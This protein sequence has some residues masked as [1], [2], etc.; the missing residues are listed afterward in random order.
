MDNSAQTPGEKKGNFHKLDILIT[1]VDS[2]LG[3]AL[4]DSLL[5][6]NCAIWGV[7][8]SPL[9][10]EL[11]GKDDFTLLE[12]DLAQPLP[13]HLPK[14]ELIFYLEL[15]RN[16]L[17]QSTLTKPSLPPPLT[18]LVS[19]V[20]KEDVKL[21]VCAPLSANLRF[22]DYLTGDEKTKA[23][24][25]VLLLGDLYGPRMP[26]VA[27]EAASTRN[28]L[29]NLVHQA[30]KTDKIILENEGL[31][32]IYPTYITDAI[33]AINKFV[34]SQKE[35]QTATVASEDAKTALSCAY[36]I[37]NALNLVGKKQIG[38][39]F[40]GPKLQVTPKV[41]ATVRV[42]HHEFAP[43]VQLSEGL[44][45]TFEYLARTKQIESQLSSQTS[46]TPQKEL[47]HTSLPETQVGS[48]KNRLTSKIPNFSSMPSVK[49]A[50]ILVVIV[51]VVGVIKT[52]ADIYWGIN[53]LKR[54]QDLVLSGD[55][56]GAKNKSKRAESSLSS[57][58]SEFK[59][60]TLPLSPILGKRATGLAQFL[61][62]ASIGSRAFSHFIDGSE[63]L[64]KY[65][66]RAA[67]KDTREN[68]LDL[69]VSAA[70]FKRAYHLSSE[71]QLLA[72]S[73]GGGNLLKSRIA[74]VENS[75]DQ[76]N[77]LSLS[78]FEL[79]NLT[80]NILGSEPKTYLVLLQN[81][82]E[83][84]PGGGFIGNFA[85]VE[86]EEG[87]LR[88]IT[89]ED[90]YTIDGQL[91][92]KI[93]PP[94]ELKDKLGVDQFYLR[95]SNWSVDF[96]LNSATARDF[97]KKETGKD[98]GGVVALDLS[99]I[100][101]VLQRIGPIVL[102]DY[103]EEITAEN[104]FE[105]GEYYSEVGFFPGSTQKRDFFGSLTR[106]LVDKV[107][108]SEKPEH[109]LALV[110]AARDALIQKHLMLSLDEPELASFVRTHKWDNS[111]PPPSFNPAD[112]NA[113]TRDFVALAEA[114][115][116][117]NKVNR[118]LER[119]I[120]YEMTI[121]R[122]ADLVA[123][124]S[125][126][127][128]N[129]SQAETWP[130]GR[131]VNFLRVYVPFAADLIEFKNGQNT[132]KNQ[133]EITTQGSLTTLATHVEVPIKSTKEII[134]VYRIPKNIQLEKAP[135]YHLYVQKQPGT[136][137]DPFEFIF[138]LP[139]YLAERETGKQNLKISTDLAVDREF[140]IEVVKK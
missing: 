102:A 62:S 114:N 105:R 112:D 140:E 33:F 53:S 127:Y 47:I 130:A 52:A 14:F 134:F 90:I 24:L 29:A 113:E 121:G 111:L 9:Y 79:S 80:P 97:Y 17:D 123:R 37:Q 12:L 63:V 74:F 66:Q 116:G 75:L 67:N 44:R 107:V 46:P 101:E 60:L 129:Q 41:E 125:I 50:L 2:Y 96:A 48:T 18:N 95:D 91:K 100:Q 104:L 68:G 73:V 23:N 89:V 13:S 88:N 99:F 103:K 64:A 5:L 6:Q 81:N 106:A 61:H 32:L 92:E 119:K 126:T 77:K 16:P 15:L 19:Y 139:N 49:K 124:L 42:S 136:T 71:A 58:A 72:K 110:E 1:D 138:N 22:V 43:K 35:K 93:E 78:L 21:F 85:T 51:L 87:K 26:L 115:L 28:E 3:S 10:Q 82:T 57:A 56:G 34:F 20:L 36:E 118:M 31:G 70:N 27:P 135:T 83:L 133:V 11:L 86:L 4:A 120:S 98:V 137:K 54:A 25:K 7:G 76:L 108:T 117:A 38:L 122:D 131:Y 30:A 8:K 40:S 94:R 109:W 45:N 84:R 65:Y 132:D 69:E 39:F 128:T 59:L 55:F